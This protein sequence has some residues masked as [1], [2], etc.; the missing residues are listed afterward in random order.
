MR[1]LSA[2]VELHQETK[3]SS[4]PPLATMDILLIDD[5]S[6]L[7]RTLRITLESMSHTVAEAAQGEAALAYLEKQHFDLAFLDLRLGKQAGMDLDSENR[8]V[9]WYV[10]SVPPFLSLFCRSSE[11]NFF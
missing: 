10:F 11:A 4:G 1:F 8:C 6:R 5:E 2:R 9:P 7:R 3:G